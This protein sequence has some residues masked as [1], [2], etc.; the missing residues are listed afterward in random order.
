[1]TEAELQALITER[2]DDLGILWFHD[3]VPYRNRC[4][5]GFPDLVLAGP[6]GPVIFAELKSDD[7][8]RSFEQARWARAIRHGG[9]HYRL[10]K[11][12]DW[13]SG[14]IQRELRE[15]ADVA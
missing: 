4:T 15:L 6:H 14:T 7:G 1:M 3:A 8:A 10:W 2:C 5:P 9:G 11:P 13:E 12:A